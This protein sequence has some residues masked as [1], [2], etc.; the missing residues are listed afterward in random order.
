MRAWALAL[1]LPALAAAAHT[2]HLQRTAASASRAALVDCAQDAQTLV[3]VAL[4]SQSFELL[5]DTG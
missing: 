2:V 3:T 5:L 4:G 1:T